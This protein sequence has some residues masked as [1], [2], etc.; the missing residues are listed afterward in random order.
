[1][2]RALGSA[3]RRRARV[4]S[5][6]VSGFQGS[7]QVVATPIGN[8]DDVSRRAHEVLSS[9]DLICCEDTRRTRALLSALSLP[10][11]PRRLRSLHGHNEAARIDGVLELLAA[12]KTVALVSDAGTPAISDPGARLVAAAIDAGFSVTAVPGPC[13]PVTALVVSGLKTDRFCFE[14]FLPRKGPERRRRL[15]VLATEERTAVVLEAPGRLSALLEELH[16]ACG[17][18]R[19]AVCRE[20]TKVHEEVWRGRLGDA[21]SHFAQTPPRGEVVVVIEGRPP[22]AVPKEAL[23][24]SIRARLAVGDGPRQAAEAVASELGVPRR[25]AYEEA[26]TQRDQARR[27]GSPPGRR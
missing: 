4:S 11:N 7:L 10:T 8:L 3:A 24:A 27:S 26:L 13:A 22:Q 18:R 1:V 6:T 2:L 14:G 17:D 16:H 25:Q 5:D 21:A 23:S 15:A 12:G 19:V 20:L 9:A